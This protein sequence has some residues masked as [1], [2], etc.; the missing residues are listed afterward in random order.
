MDDERLKIRLLVHRL[1]PIISMR[2]WSASAIFAPAN[3]G[4]I[5]AYER[6]LPVVRAFLPAPCPAYAIQIIFGPV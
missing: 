2:C 6:Y 5:C 1:Y 3:A 4:F